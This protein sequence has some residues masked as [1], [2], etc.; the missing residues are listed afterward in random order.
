[1]NNYDFLENAINKK[2]PSTK[3]ILEE[4]YDIPKKIPT[5][6]IKQF[7]F[8][9]KKELI[10][11]YTELFFEEKG[12]TPKQYIKGVK[13]SYKANQRR[14]QKKIEE[15]NKFN[16]QSI[17]FKYTENE[18]EQ[19]EDPA[20]LKL[21]I[22]NNNI[23]GNNRIIISFG[24]E[25]LRD[26]D[27]DIQGNI[28]NWWDKDHQKF[29]GVSPFYVF[30]YPL[31]PNIFWNGRTLTITITK[32]TTL[33]PEYIIQNFLDGAN[34]HC[35]FNPILDFC[36]NAI[37]EAK[38]KATEE[39]YRAIQTKI[40][41]KISTSER[42]GYIEKYKLGIP[43]DQIQRVCDDLR[44]SINVEQP[45]TNTPYLKIQSQKKALKQFNFVNTRTNHIELLNNKNHFD[46]IHINDFKNVIILT[47]EEIR[48]KQQELD[49]C[50]I[51]YIY[52]KDKLGVC[53]IKSISNVYSIDNDFINTI[54]DF[55]KSTGL[56]N[57]SIDYFKNPTLTNF[58]I[59]GTHHNGTIDFKEGVNQKLLEKE[60]DKI[61]HIDMSKAYTQYKKSRYYNGFVGKITDFRKVDNYN[62][63]GLYYIDNINFDK[64][65][66]KFI[67]YNNALK[68]FRNKNIY[69]D[70]ELTALADL[71]AIFDVKYGAYGIKFDF[72][73]NHDMVNKKEYQYTDDNGE[74]IA[75]SYFSKFC[76]I[77]AKISTKKKFYMKGD[78]TYLEQL[79]LPETTELKIPNYTKDEI[80]E[81][82]FYMDKDYA[83]HKTHIMA[84]I[85]AYQRLNMLE[86]LLNMNYDDIIRICVDGI[87]YY[88]HKFKINDIF[89]DKHQERNFKNTAGKQYLSRVDRE[90]EGFWKPTAQPREFYKKQL[91]LGGGGCGK[92]HIN[93][94]DEGLINVIYIA[95]SW[96][97]A[98]YKKKEFN[99]LNVSVLHRLV[100]EPYSS[101]IIKKY[102][103]YIID[104]ASFIKQ[105]E[106]EFIFNNCGGKM[107]FCGDLGF[108]LQPVIS[109]HDRKLVSTN[110]IKK[111]DIME[112]N[113]SGFDNITYCN[114]NYRSGSCKKLMKI[115]STLR[116][117]IKNNFNGDLDEV[118]EVMKKQTNTINKQQLKLQYIKEDLILS[119]ENYICDEYTE[120]FKHLEKYRIEKNSRDYNNGEIVY[121]KIDK[122]DMVLKHGFTI[123]CIQG[124]TASNKLYIDATK[125]KSLR[126]L[127]TAIS[128]ARTIEQIIFITE[129]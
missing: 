13:I 39:R 15:K 9:N 63:K 5:Y 112:M 88:D 124:E 120:T 38:S 36:D 64:C 97:L 37:R 27:V 26:V 29:I 81:G 48:E 114:T 8:N 43:E 123:H 55:E 47:R 80:V 129:K 25:N 99:N 12:K 96:K 52:K 118:I 23:T 51:E 61:R 116:E 62:Q 98:S 109:Q 28:N 127:Y 16:N 42:Y 11:F 6:K 126:M 56:D 34:T 79:R 103:N 1:M 101:E 85:T 106:K 30:Q 93:L 82:S 14:E 76:G 69:T 92:T 33:E 122:I 87:Y 107:I 71:G 21:L 59:K 45:F 74:E 57:C 65:I 110:K 121:K 60:G 83:T 70:A 19:L 95:P 40:T 44:I 113:K 72:E 68:W 67:K 75:V 94:T 119:S 117:M 58:L 104:E 86:Q 17:I 90:V 46:N 89:R 50:R 73:F 54:S 111:T 84:Q 7:G 3:E 128:R 41:T 10:Q 31:Y 100:N 77:M 66:P 115:L 91:F 2:N 49:K 24:N 20:L 32:N 102:N 4:Y 53:C 78:K 105:Y 108:Q 18:E 35:F 125:N 22:K